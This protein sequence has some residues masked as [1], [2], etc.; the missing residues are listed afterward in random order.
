VTLQRLIS[1]IRWVHIY[2]TMLGFGL[3]C[4]FA[5]TGILLNHR[6]GLGLD[7]TK[8]TT[9]TGTLPAALVKNASQPEVLQ[10]LRR[11]FGLAGKL[12]TFE[13]EDARIRIMFERPGGH[14]EV[15]IDRSDGRIEVTT[16]SGG[17]LGFVTD[18]HRGHGAS[19]VWKVA[20]DITAALLLV[21]SLTGLALGLSLS[22]RR[23]VAL[24]LASAGMVACAWLAWLASS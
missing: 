18:L 14:S 13:V 16:E 2:L 7:E 10:E 21:S 19:R 23:G 3:M 5:V 9:A 1:P 17:V 4:L 20:I 8:T 22:R 15:M 11:Q 6:E 24:I 12:D